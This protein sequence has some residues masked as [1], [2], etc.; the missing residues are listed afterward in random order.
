ML[1][2][3]P[4]IPLPDIY[5][6]TER[7]YQLVNSYLEHKRPVLNQFLSKDGAKREETKSI[8]Y[9]KEHVQTWLDEIN[10]MNA[11]GMRVYFGTY[12]EKSEIAPGQ[13]CLLM[14]LTRAGENAGTHIDLIY[15]NEPGFSE[16]M[17]ASKSRSSSKGSYDME[18][19]PRPHNYGSPCPPIC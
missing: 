3:Q 6:G 1:E 18:E 16:R 15:E 8:W 19:R 11:D 7:V 14:M 2:S 5:I 17:E 10:L 12:D 13:L 4:A 9:S